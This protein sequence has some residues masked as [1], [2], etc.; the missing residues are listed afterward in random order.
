M[1]KEVVLEINVK[2]I[3]Y[4]W[5]VFIFPDSS[6]FLKLKNI[7]HI[8]PCVDK[9]SS[10]ENIFLFLYNQGLISAHK[11]RVELIKEEME[12][13]LTTV[14]HTNISFHITDKGILLLKGTEEKP[15][16]NQFKLNL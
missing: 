9:F 11:A 12:S 10:A 3:I 7:S 5:M 13:N 15:I 4:R 14:I 16:D 1:A 8:L 6:H 2:D